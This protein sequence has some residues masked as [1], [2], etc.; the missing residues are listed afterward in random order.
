MLSSLSRNARDGVSR[1]SAKFQGMFDL[2]V[3]SLATFF[4]GDYPGR[5]AV[6]VPRELVAEADGQRVLA[7]DVTYP[8]GLLRLTETETNN[9]RVLRIE[10]LADSLVMDAVIRFVLPLKVVESVALNNTVIPWR[11]QN[12]YHQVERAVADIE[13]KDGTALRLRPFA[14]AAG[15]PEGLFLMT[16]LRDEPN[17][18]ILHIRVRANKPTHFSTRGCVSW[19][20]RP[21]P[22]WAQAVFRSIP[23]FHAATLL[24]RERLSQR[25]P[26][27]TNGAVLL[28]KGEA[29]E[30]GV[31]WENC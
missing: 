21:F 14:G 25:I 10:A 7:Y 11:R 29:F 17:A 18:W 30:F 31:T 12:K 19:Y 22:G 8:D 24:I 5:G 13:F 20:N 4:S 1:V 27:Q 26:F 9:Q 6:S 15:L 2:E 3:G 23:G 28:K 16:Y